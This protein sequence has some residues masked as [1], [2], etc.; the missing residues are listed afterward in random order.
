[1]IRPM[2]LFEIKMKCEMMMSK[3]VMTMSC[4]I[5][6]GMTISLMV[7]MKASLMK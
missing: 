4:M 7:W 3:M 2:S 1:M 5:I 6:F